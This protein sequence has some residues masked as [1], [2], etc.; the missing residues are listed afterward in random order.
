M[1]DKMLRPDEIAEK[2]SVDVRTVY[3]WISNGDLVAVKIP[4]QGR[5]W[6]IAKSDFESFIELYKNTQ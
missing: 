3:R 6:R 5:I 4:K 2:L 1:T